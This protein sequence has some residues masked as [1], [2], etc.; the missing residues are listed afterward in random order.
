M[1]TR[2][3]PTPVEQLR[4]EDIRMR[5]PFILEPF[6]GEFVLLGPRT[7]AS[8]EGPRLASTATSAMISSAGRAPCRVPP[9][10]RLLGR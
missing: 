1:P 10:A 7:R 4:L 3:T 5:D 8:G 2:G 6:P 9:P